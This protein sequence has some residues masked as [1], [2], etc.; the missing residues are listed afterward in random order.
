MLF[1][2]NCPH[3]LGLWRRHDAQIALLL[4]RPDMPNAQFVPREPPIASVHF[5]NIDA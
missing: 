3:C 1:F 4:D 5:L 2:T